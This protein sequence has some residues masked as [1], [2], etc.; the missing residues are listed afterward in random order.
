[1]K[2]EVLLP[3]PPGEGRGEGTTLAA[4][5]RATA[6][7]LAHTLA[8][9]P[10]EARLEAQVLA[11]HTLGV[12]RAWL[13]AHGDEYL[14]PQQLSA[15]R[16]LIERRVAGEPVAYILGEREFHGLRLHVS[17]D[18]LIPRPDTET[19][20]RAA[21]ER[22]PPDRACRILDLGTGS[23]AVALAL[24]RQ[25]PQAA[26]IA[27]DASPAALAVAR[28]N[29]ERLEI[30]NVAFRQSDWYAELGVKKFDM[31]VA[32]PPYVADDDPHLRQGDLRYEPQRAL[33]AGADGLGAIRRIV[34]GA[35]DH[36]AEGGWLLFE[37]GWDQAAACRDLLEHHGFTAIQAWPDLAGIPRVSGGKRR[38][39]PPVDG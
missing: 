28:G 17:P 15:T 14:G 30:A 31:I 34:A 27:V 23:G 21:L 5:I 19:L 3:L 32:N 8:L 16:V 18:V 24:A 22:I 37:H 12:N 25:R 11:A 36:L 2:A 13:I 4:L 10:R 6:D 26:I 9:P 29:A 38:D 1:M 39:V 35:P 7:R 33:R 20:V